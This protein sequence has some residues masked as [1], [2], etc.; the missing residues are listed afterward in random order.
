MLA[1]RPAGASRG[2]VLFS[3]I[4][5]PLLDLDRPVPLSHT[6]FWE[7]R[8][9]ALTFR[10]LGFTVDCL[11]WTNRTFVPRHPYD[12][13]VD[14][15]RNFDRIA[16]QL[17]PRCIKIF[18]AETAHHSTHNG[19]QQRR[20]A[21]LEQRR[22]IRLAPFKLVEVNRAA[23][24]ADH[25]TILGNDFTAAT[26]RYAG[27]PVHRIPI[28]TPMQFPEPATKAFG[29]ARTR[30]LWFG[31]EG[32]VHKGLDLVLD[33]FAGLP[34][35]DLIV[36]GPL[37]SEPAFEAAYAKELYGLPNVRTTGWMDIE[38]PAF[39]RVLDSSVALVYPS[40][41]EGGGGCVVGCMHAGLIPI[42]TPEASVDVT[43]ET[44]V[45]LPAAS[46]DAI[47]NAVRALAGTP[48][49][50]LRATAH[51]AWSFARAN[52]TRERFAAAYRAFAE[53]LTS[54]GK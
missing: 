33:A 42:V 12:V 23:E 39:T 50:R 13:Y 45:V 41:S 25:I 5:D 27:K 37:D 7:S 53:T 54:R 8:Q 52:H 2:R 17:P 20:L 18:H 16:P 6:H 3:Y 15:R 31:S 36:C 35:M 28:S 11:H 22:G 10:E 44:G 14:V 40:C 47:R 1:L 30:F 43:P 26:F 49:E 48:P 32:F 51:A 38:S 19:A 34:E 29:A 4:L 9:M 21:E 24:Q 46:V